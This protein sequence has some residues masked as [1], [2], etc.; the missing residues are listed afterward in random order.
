M[1][2]D[3]CE[4]FA[5]AYRNGGALV[6]NHDFLAPSRVPEPGDDMSSAHGVEDLSE[7][8]KIL[9]DAGATLTEILIS[10]ALLGTIVVAMSTA[11][12]AMVRTSSTVF[13][14]AQVETVL[15]NASDLVE[16]SEQQCNYDSALQGAADAAEWP[17]GSVTA[18][19]EILETN[20]GN[21][22]GDWT[23]VVDCTEAVEA[24]DVQRLVIRATHPTE[25]ITRT[26]TVV[27]SNVSN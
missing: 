26:L 23:L 22:G 24:F 19:V 15:L 3:G 1:W 14:L 18:T 27:K 11:V 4:M 8:P 7:N 10:I 16:R 2:R 6:K 13:E 17:T 12:L 20:T 9:R 5:P 25:E 21:P